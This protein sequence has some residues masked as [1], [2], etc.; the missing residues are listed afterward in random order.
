MRKNKNNK[1]SKS[2]SPTVKVYSKKLGRELEA[3]VT[4]NNLSKELYETIGMSNGD[5]GS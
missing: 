3:K 1:N 2:A 5:Y 4:P